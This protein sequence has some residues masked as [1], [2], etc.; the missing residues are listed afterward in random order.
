MIAQ[1]SHGILT[2]SVAT[3]IRWSHMCRE[4]SKYIA[5]GRF[6]VVHLIESLL[7]GDRAEIFMTPSMASYLVSLCIHTPDK[8]RTD[9][10]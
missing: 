10:R 3:G 4:E 6:V 2:V 8:S 7:C 1:R 9:S 5:E